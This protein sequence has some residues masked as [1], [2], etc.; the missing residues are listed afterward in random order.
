MQPVVAEG[1]GERECQ[2]DTW[3]SRAPG[4]A[5]SHTGRAPPQ[6]ESR[7]RGPTHGT[8]PRTTQ[9]PVIC[10]SMN[11]RH[12]RYSRLSTIYRGMQ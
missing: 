4:W 11:R 6:R 7:V 8:T 2:A 9:A 5:G 12:W 3:L 10:I 1:K